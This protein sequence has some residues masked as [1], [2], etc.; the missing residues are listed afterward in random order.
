MY[1]ELGATVVREVAK[2][3]LMRR[4]SVRFDKEIGAVV[5]KLPGEAEEEFLL[6]PALVRRN[7]TSAASINEWTGEKMLDDA[8]VPEGVRPETISPLGNYAVQ[9]TWEDGFNQVASFDLLAGLERMALPEGYT[10]PSSGGGS[11][12]QEILSAATASAG[13]E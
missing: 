4:N 1:G 2:L 7:D 6:S 13:S 11:A 12:A 5:V 10:G 8:A 9:I 3:K